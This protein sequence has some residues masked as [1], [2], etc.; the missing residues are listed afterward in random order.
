MTDEQSVREKEVSKMEVHI[1]VQLPQHRSGARLNGK[2]ALIVGVVNTVMG[3]D[4]PHGAVDDGNTG[5]VAERLV[6]K[7]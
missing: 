4:V 1:H 7:G 6:G 2:N 5:N 3:E